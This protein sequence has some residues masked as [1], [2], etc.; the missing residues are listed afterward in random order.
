VTA[1]LAYPSPPLADPVVALRPWRPQDAPDLLRGFGDPVVQRF[2]WPLEHYTAADAD[3]FLAGREPGRLRGEELSFALVAPGGDGALLGGGSLHAVELHEARAAVGYWL[4]PAARGR[5]VASR[6]VRLMAGWAF[7]ALGVARLELTCA[8]DN[9]ASQRVAERC[10][11]TR[12]G[13]LRSHMRFKGAR[14]DT[15]V[16]GLLDGELR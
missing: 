6:A 15:L 7:A 9:A 8:P 3:A 11:F 13:L 10:G 5:G 1:A 16:F 2:S 14:R 12:E 4:V